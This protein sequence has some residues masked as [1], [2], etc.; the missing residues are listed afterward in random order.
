MDDLIE[1]FK[2]LSYLM[3]ARYAYQAAAVNEFNCPEP[4]CERALLVLRMDAIWPMADGHED[5]DRV[6]G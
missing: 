1:P 3:V 2:G 5:G 4:R 6:G